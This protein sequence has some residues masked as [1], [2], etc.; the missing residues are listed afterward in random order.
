MLNEYGSAVSSGMFSKFVIGLKTFAKYF[1][2]SEYKITLL[3]M[4]N[5]SSV[6][7]TFSAQSFIASADA[8]IDCFGNIM[9]YISIIIN[10]TI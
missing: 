2:P 10:I 1:I 4:K 3:I 8:F 6:G 9:Q 5:G 7:N